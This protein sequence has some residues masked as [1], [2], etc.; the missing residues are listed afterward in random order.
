MVRPPL[1]NQVDSPTNGNLFLNPLYA[2]PYKVYY[3][4]YFILLYG[5]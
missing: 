5:D 2:Y 3:L 1:L 4:T